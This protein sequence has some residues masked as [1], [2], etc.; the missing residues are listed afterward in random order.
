MATG[1]L[2]MRRR[3]RKV[4][5]LPRIGSLSFLSEEAPPSARSRVF[6]QTP[7]SQTK[8]VLALKTLTL[9]LVSSYLRSTRVRGQFLPP[10]PTFNTILL[11]PIGSSFSSLLGSLF[12]PLLAARCRDF[13]PGF[14]VKVFGGEEG[15][16]R[17]GEYLRQ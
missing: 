5:S 12:L 2:I 1:S 11:V 15:K 3:G 4:I 6:K 16:V 7:P 14:N 13:F 9:V 10:S 8:R 17:E